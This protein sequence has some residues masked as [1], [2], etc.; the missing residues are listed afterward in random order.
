MLEGDVKHKI[1]ALA[2][3]LLALSMAASC[4]GTKTSPTPSPPATELPVATASPSPSPPATSPPAVDAPEP[5]GF[6]IDPSMKLG[7]VVGTSPNRSIEWGAGPEALSYSRD[8][9]PA[10]DPGRANGAGWDCRVHVEY[11]GQPAVDLYVPVGTPI[12]ATM[13][14]T[15]TLNVVTVTNAFDYYG[16]AREPF[17]GNPDRLRAAVSPFPGVGGGKGV[18]VTVENDDFVT[19][20]GHLDPARTFGGVSAEAF[21]PGYSSGSDFASMF[22]PLRDFRVFTPVARWAVKREEV[23]G[24]SGDSGYSEAPHLHYAIRRAGESSLL[25]PTNE[26]GF[27]DGGWLLR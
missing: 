26:A 14:G 2:A 5:R 27:E 15:A 6:P 25:C 23:I 19:D 21:L 13:D 11:E 24:Y 1:P 17:L 20:Y 12:R 3:L 22:A 9:Q 18:F 10:G 8:D 16:V 4:R 7:V